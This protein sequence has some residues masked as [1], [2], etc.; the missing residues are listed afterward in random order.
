MVDRATHEVRARAVPTLHAN[1]QRIEHQ[2]TRALDIEK[3][4]PR[5]EQ[6]LI[7]HCGGSWMVHPSVFLYDN[8]EKF[9]SEFDMTGAKNLMRKKIY[10]VHFPRCS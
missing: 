10:S 7:R 6:R 9:H 1:S 4:C 3:T 8:Q 5:S 2:R